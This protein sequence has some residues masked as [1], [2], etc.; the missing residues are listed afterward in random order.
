MFQRLFGVDAGRHVIRIAHRQ[1]A[2]VEQLGPVGLLVDGDLILLIAL[3]GDQHQFVTQQRI[4]GVFHH[5]LLVDGVIHPLLIGGDEQIGW[6][7]LLNLARQ[8]RRGRKGGNHLH[9]LAF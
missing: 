7:A 6:G 1:T 4:A 8:R 2:A 5:L 3:G 9:I